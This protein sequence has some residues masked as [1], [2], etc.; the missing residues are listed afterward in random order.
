MEPLVP[1]RR[2]EVLALF[3]ALAASAAPAARAC[4]DC[5]CHRYLLAPALPFGNFDARANRIAVA[6]RID[7]GEMDGALGCDDAGIAGFVNLQPRHRAPHAFAHLG[8]AAPAIDVPAHDAGLLLCVVLAP[9]ADPARDGPA[10]IRGALDLAAARGFALVDAFPRRDAT[11]L[12]PH[13]PGPVA[14]L[15]AAGF[16]SLGEQG[17]RVALRR[18]LR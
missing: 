1:Q 17:E 18:R 8:V 11:T 6:A 14:W 10:L 3:D 12:A 13:E 15:E 16:A 9:R 5:C 2:D 4:G 7:T